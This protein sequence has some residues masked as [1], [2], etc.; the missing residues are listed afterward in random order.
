MEDPVDVREE[1][2]DVVSGHDE[3]QGGQSRGD[4]FLLGDEEFQAL[5]P[6]RRSFWRDFFEGNVLKDCDEKKHQERGP[7]V[8]DDG[9]GFLGQPVF[10]NHSLG[11]GDVFE[12][13]T[14]EDQGYD[15]VL[16]GDGTRVGGW[17][18]GDEG[19]HLIEE[20]EAEWSG[21][22]GEVVVP[23]TLDDQGRVRQ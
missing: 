21:D 22:G 12:D 17:Q 11:S 16:V 1:E 14:D 6:L 3:Q 13:I 20:N 9:N 2:N 4:D 8:E 19:Q 5:R 18:R 23:D 7:H 10:D 15:L